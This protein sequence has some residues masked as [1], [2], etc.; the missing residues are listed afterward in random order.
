MRMAIDTPALYSGATTS[1]TVADDGH[2]TWQSAPKFKN[3]DDARF[4]YLWLIELTQSAGALW[5]KLYETVYQ[6][7]T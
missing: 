1:M 6:A 7:R 4:M 3:D 5:C 2:M